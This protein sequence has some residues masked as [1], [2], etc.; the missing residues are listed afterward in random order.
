MSRPVSGAFAFIAVVAAVLALI[1]VTQRRLIYFPV[2]HLPSLDDVGLTGGEAVTF[3]TSDGLRLGAWFLAGT[4]PPPRLTILVFNGNAGNRAHRAPLA[5]S[6]R[7]HGLQVLLTDYRG[8]GGNPGSPSEDGLAADAR[9]A[10]AYLLSRPEVDPARLVYFGESLGS[11]V[12]VRLAVEHTPQALIVRS[13]FTSLVDLGRHHYPWLPVRLLLRDRFASLD[14]APHI[15]SP[16]LVIAGGRDAVVPIDQSRRLY[17]AVVTPKT[18][19]ELPGADHNDDALLSGDDMM[20]S[21][22][23]FLRPF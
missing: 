22:L 13:P 1:W 20:W 11:A 2:T 8:Y 15:R 12:A 7:R 18:L 19:V 5:A 21:M 10:L 16:V 3:H 23:R 14:R 4:G 17:D 6:L 9:A